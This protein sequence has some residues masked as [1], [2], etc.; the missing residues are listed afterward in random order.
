M[1]KI[2]VILMLL[3]VVWRGAAQNIYTV[4][5]LNETS[6][7]KTRKPKK[8][9][10]RIHSAAE[11][12]RERVVK[13][14]DAGMPVL[15]ERYDGGGTLT[16]RLRYTNDTGRR[17]TLSRIMERWTSIGH[18]EEMA[19]YKYDSAGFLVG[20]TDQ[21]GYGKTLDTYTVVNNDKGYPVELTGFG[22]D[23]RVL[24]RET[25]AYRYDVN[26][27]VTQV[28]SG[29]GRLVS[30]DTLKISFKDAYLYPGWGEQYNEQ[31]DATHFISIRVN[32]AVDA[33]QEEYTY[34]PF[35]NCTEEKIYKVSERGD[36]RLVLSLDRVFRR[37][38]VY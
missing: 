7:Y 17:V 6:D 4:L 28:F 1:L 16:T 31:G 23:G 32:G 18:M 8:I 27:V 29:D 14:F 13:T 37:E 19:L 9:V 5:H 12:D 2:A 11:G 22:P 25:G 36:G 10:E 26:K 20:I 38:Y 30:T 24:G 34:D 33:F 21:D 3:L 35:G 15:E